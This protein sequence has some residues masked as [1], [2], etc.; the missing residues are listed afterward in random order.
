MKTLRSLAT[1]LLVVCFFIANN[2]QL[3]AIEPLV[4]AMEIEQTQEN[5]C[6]CGE[7]IN[8]LH[9]KSTMLS[10]THNP[11]VHESCIY[12]WCSKKMQEELTPACPVCRCAIHNEQIEKITKAQ[13][14]LIA[15]SEG[16]IDTIKTALDDGI[17]I[18]N[19]REHTTNAT[20]LHIAAKY[21]NHDVIYRL[22][23]TIKNHDELADFINTKTDAGFTAL[24]IAAI[25]GNIPS[26]R[27]LFTQLDSIARNS[28]IITQTNTGQTALHLVAQ[29]GPEECVFTLLAPLIN[30]QNQVDFIMTKDNAGNT[31]LNVAAQYGNDEVISAMLTSLKNA[32]DR[33]ALIN[34]KSFQTKT[35]A[36]HLAAAMGKTD[37]L[38]AIQDY[39]PSASTEP[40]MAQLV[41]GGTTLHIAAEAGHTDIVYAL[42]YSLENSD[43]LVALLNVKTHEGAT[44][45]HLAAQNGHIIIMRMLLEAIERPEDKLAYANIQT[46]KGATA[47]H[48][49]IEYAH[50]FATEVLL[51]DIKR[52]ENE[53]AFVKFINAKTISG[54]TALHIATQHN[55]KKI[56]LMLCSNF[57]SDKD[58]RNLIKTKNINGDTALHVAAKAGLI[59]IVLIL[60]SRFENDQ[61]RTAFINTKNNEGFSALDLAAVNN[62]RVMVDIFLTKMDDGARLAYTAMLAYEA[63]HLH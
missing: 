20:A 61:E 21:N 1:F 28:I 30:D 12:R 5:C 38:V 2:L 57:C 32:N 36:I 34:T 8:S 60:L 33:L 6:I 17:D 29:K 56:I 63:T 26:M 19:I 37:A 48:L 27:L 11:M 41:N 52:T 9:P 46:N 22:L 42:L 44:A 18:K 47:L 53:D 54:D 40:L 35:T 59:D 23:S 14:F 16:N 4:E 62:H 50:C 55:Q 31:A 7:K 58:R 43:D 39:I 45:L 15:V 24:H 3:R 13:A 49:A 25:N 51:V 10:C